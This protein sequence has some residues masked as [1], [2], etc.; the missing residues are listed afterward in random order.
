MKWKS[1]IF[2]LLVVLFLILNILNPAKAM[3]G[4]KQGL[5]LFLGTVLPALLPFFA[6]TTMFIRSGLAHKL[7]RF[8][9]PI[10]RPLFRLPG[11][12]ALAFVIACFGGNPNGSRM[13]SELYEQGLL[14]KA[15]AERTIA[16]A[17]TAG[18]V[19]ILSIVAGEMLKAPQYGLL[20][21]G[22]H[23]LTAIVVCQ[24]SSLLVA[25]QTTGEIPKKN[26]AGASRQIPSQIFVDSVRDC[27][28]S[29]WG[30]GSFIIFF[31]TLA[32]LC[33]SIGLYQ[34]LAKPL[35]LLLNPLG[36][37][38]QLAEPF[39]KGI[40]EITEGCNSVSALSL[41]VTQKLPVLCAIVSF[42]GSSALA[43][44]FL[45]ARKCEMRISRLALYNGTQGVLGLF[46]C[47]IAIRLIPVPQ[48]AFA[49]VPTTFDGKLLNSTAFFLYA[50][51]VLMALGLILGIVSFIFGKI[52]ARHRPVR[53]DS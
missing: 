11:A 43:Q 2:P 33:E 28:T 14:T 15:E 48:A 13:T 36:L 45:F 52:N 3:L 20:L 46:F 1:Q 40:M 26:A 50:I 34:I 17:S 53:I 18:P 51:A 7:A 47:T 23:F 25:K 35:S 38:P 12:S 37:S 5:Q 22:C 9:S 49:Q 32:T 30:V 19:F 4:A 31:G 16:L 8:L 10:M 24:L 42:G 6:G 29:L 27:A 21:W 44:N 41:S 39:I